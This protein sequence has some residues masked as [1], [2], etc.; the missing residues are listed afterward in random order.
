MSRRGDFSVSGSST[1]GVTS[2]S[3]SSGTTIDVTV[4]GGDLASF[5]GTVGL[6]LVGGQNIEDS[7]GNALP[8]AEPVTDET[9]LLDN[10]APS[11]TSFCA[12]NAFGRV[13]EF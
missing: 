8:D 13:N 10:T 4:S 9:Y 1:A 11:L 3:A 7:V 2:V 5:D 6:N 12:S